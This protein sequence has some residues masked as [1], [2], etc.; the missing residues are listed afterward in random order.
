MQRSYSTVH[1]DTFIR[2]KFVKKNHLPLELSDERS[3]AEVLA[4]EGELVICWEN[5]G[6]TSLGGTYGNGYD[7]SYCLV[8]TV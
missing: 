4:F 6:D 2:L 7:H 3:L 1:G 5:Q 8:F